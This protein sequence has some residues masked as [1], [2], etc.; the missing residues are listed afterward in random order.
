MHAALRDT[1]YT[2][3]DVHQYTGTKQEYHGDL[4]RR[5]LNYI[6]AAHCKHITLCTHAHI[7]TQTAHTKS[8]RRARDGFKVNSSAFGP[9]LSWETV[10]QKA[11]KTWK[12]KHCLLR[13]HHH[14]GA[15]S[16][17][18]RWWGFF[19]PTLL[20]AFS[21]SFLFVVFCPSFPARERERQMYARA[22]ARPLSLCSCSA[23]T[24]GVVV[25]F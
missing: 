25:A 23:R 5:A 16:R 10:P 18:N 4:L 22:H 7:H 15:S 20:C 1:G 17:R 3:S 13:S 12:H 6:A 8:P 9:F 19:F 21:F 2:H 14:T 11:H 24:T